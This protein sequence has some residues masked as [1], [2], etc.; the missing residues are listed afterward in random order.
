MLN[1]Y[2]LINSII[3]SYTNSVIEDVKFFEKNGK[4]FIR[5][6]PIHMAYKLS[7]QDVF[8]T[9]N[10]VSVMMECVLLNQEAIELFGIN[11]DEKPGKRIPKLLAMKLTNKSS[12]TMIIGEAIPFFNSLIRNS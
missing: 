1:K 3:D 7:K 8:F 4:I 6:Y 5:I 2:Y 9:K 10:D 11:I 12:T